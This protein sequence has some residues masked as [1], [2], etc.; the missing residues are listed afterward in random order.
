MADIKERGNKYYLERL[1][2]EHPGVH[3][4][5]EAG[6]YSSPA[7][8]LRAAGIKKKR[9]RQQELENA[10]AKASSVE[11]DAFLRNNGLVAAPSGSTAAGRLIAV[12][13]RLEP[14]ARLRVEKIVSSRQMTIGDVMRELGLNPR[15]TSLGTALAR[16]TKLQPSTVSK[17]EK[18]I[19]MN[20]AH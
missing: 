6:K 18:W 13:N 15:D 1:R 9:T 4:D 12:D 3:A 20:T 14:W 5:L 8:A 11:R 16:E 2:A 10:W 7:A 19:E 17:L